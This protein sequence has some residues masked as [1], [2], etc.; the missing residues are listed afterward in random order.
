MKQ[1]SLNYKTGTIGLEDVNAPVLQPGGVLVQSRY[2]V[3]SAGTEGKKVKEGKMSYLGKAR[4]RP[5]QLGKVLD[6]LRQQGPLATYRKVMNRLDSLT[7]LGYSLS[8][9]V[10]TVGSSAQEFTVG[11][12]VACAGGRYANHAEVNFV[13]KNL[14]VPVPDN[15]SMKHAAFATLGAIVLHGFRQAEM[16]LGETAC[17]IGLGLLGQILVQVLCAAGVHVVGVDLLESRCKLATELGATVATTP[18]D[19]ALRPTIMRSTAGIGVDVIFITAGGSSNEPVELA[20]E[21]ARDRAR[22]VDIGRTRLDLPWMEY[23]EKELDVRFSR[24]YGPG[25]YDPNYE[26]LG[27][28]Y[29]IGYVRW[30]E[31]RNMAAFLDLVAAS[32]VLLD[33]IIS[34]VYPFAEAE[35]VYQQ[36]AEE[37]GNDLGL[38]FQYPEHVEATRR[39]PDLGVSTRPRSATGGKV[40][41]GV[42]GAGN[43]ASSVLLP[44][45]ARHKDV[46]LAEV[47]TATGLSGANAA[48][49][50]A[51]GRVT[52]DYQALL[53]A[54]D[55]DAVIIATRHASH[56]SMTAEA[57][58][59]GKAVFVEKPLAIDMGGVRLVQRAIEE[60]GN[61]RLL[62]GFN[63]RFS[64]LVEKLGAYLKSVKSPLVLHYRV[65]AGQMAPGSWYLDPSQGSRFVGEAGHFLDVFSFLTQARPVSVMA[66]T[67]R[68][69]QATQDDLE[70]VT[71]IVNYKDGSVGNLLYLTQGGVKVPKEYLEVFGGGRT[72]QLNNFRWLTLFEDRARHKVKVRALN[73]GHKQELHAFVSAV[74]SGR[75]MPIPLDSLL[76][77][78]LTTLAVTESLRTGQPVELADYWA[79]EG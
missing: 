6:T 59:A 13:P 50:F 46:Y 40:R 12:R 61:E 36:M 4:A 63:R 33:P 17:V 42:I 27:I 76:H 73:K 47:A 69:E 48:E 22:V 72:A 44:H 29:P 18:G 11:Q 25:R 77:T 70:N 38:V 35:R 24:S 32:R 62:V 37:Q 54:L 60:S 39:L 75:E 45:L 23:Y 57:L 58:R 8:G 65:H 55:I 79:K 67:L 3:I 21:I 51:F 2:S 41:L 9:V 34:A 68:P 71:V 74:K 31:R 1:V 53:E 49:K 64:P 30:T 43:Y 7:P 10:T 15:V 19:T 56:A 14:V 16:Q 66:T 20:A 78:T 5:D 26:E 28:D 52:T